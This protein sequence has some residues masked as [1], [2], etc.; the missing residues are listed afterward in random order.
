MTDHPA[1]PGLAPAPT[2][3]PEPPRVPRSRLALALGLLL[4]LVILDVA[5]A[6]TLRTARSPHHQADVLAID[7]VANMIRDWQVDPTELAQVA[8]SQR[9]SGPRALPALALLDALLLACALALGVPRLVVN[10]DLSRLA[11]MS[12]FLAGLG[13]LLGAVAGGVTAIARTRFL[14]ATYLSPPLGTLTYLLRY[15]SFPRA[16]ALA[17]LAVLMALKVAACLVLFHAYPRA[18]SERG[19]PGLALTAVGATVVTALCYSLAPTSL[20]GITDALAASV[21]SLAAVGWAGVLV[22]GAV[23]RLV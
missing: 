21:V 14:A 22:S 1:A 3:L 23:R 9:P 16:A 20:A 6:A 11:T 10:R 13:I 19:L 5:A 2:P 18:R 15:G 4:A 12:R 17:A 7:G 8:N